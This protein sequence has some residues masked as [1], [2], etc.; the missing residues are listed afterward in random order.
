[1]QK[2]DAGTMWWPQIANVMPKNRQ[3]NA[4]LIAAAPDL[5]EACSEIVAEWDEAHKG[6]DHRTGIAAEPYGVKLAR[7]AIAKAESR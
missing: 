1:M 7:A 4:R 3:A 2:N 6:E 5:I